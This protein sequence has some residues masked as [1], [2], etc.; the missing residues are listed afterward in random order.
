MDPVTV[1]SS[2]YAALLASPVAG[3]T[4]IALRVLGRL[5]WWLDLLL[6]LALGGAAFAGAYSFCRRQAAEAMAATAADR[7][8][9][10]TLVDG[11]WR[12]L[13]PGSNHTVD[14]ELWLEVGI[15]AEL[16]LATQGTAPVRFVVQGL[17][18]AELLVPGRPRT[19]RITP[20]AV[21]DHLLADPDS[22][23]ETP[24]TLH[25]VAAAAFAAAPWR[26]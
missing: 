3:M 7:R 8:Y 4:F 23:G 19:V 16:A 24:A 17:G 18:L 5:P 1:T 13:H 25:V 11:H 12:F 6:A 10:V 9:Q 2:L 15:T 22:S 26:R 14:D 21:G 20:G